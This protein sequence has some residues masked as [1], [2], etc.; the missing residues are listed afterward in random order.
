MQSERPGP[1]R[2]CRLL[3]VDAAVLVVSALA[4]VLVPALT[5]AAKK[6]QLQEQ[7]AERLQITAAGQAGVVSTWLQGTRRLA[8]PVVGSDLL[9]LFSTAMDLAGGDMAQMVAPPRRASPG[10]GVPL[11]PQDPVIHR[12]HRHF[13]L[14]AHLLNP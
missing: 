10:H 2:R 7:T 12:T 3:E 6:S 13:D 14:T 11:G 1:G 5:I 8:D 9:R 4:A